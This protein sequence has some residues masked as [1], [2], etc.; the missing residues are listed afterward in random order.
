M[1]G[2]WSPAPG[3]WPG[4]PVLPWDAL[5]WGSL[6]VVA[7]LL[8]Q[9]VPPPASESSILPPLLQPAPQPFL[10]LGKNTRVG[11]IVPRSLQDRYCILFLAILNI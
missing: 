3:P 2:G 6:A 7:L 9:K 5:L 4:F 8:V 11:G 1:T 10:N